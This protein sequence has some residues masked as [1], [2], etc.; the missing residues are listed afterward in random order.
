MSKA[1]YNAFHLNLRLAEI[2]KQARIQVEAEVLRLPPNYCGF[3]FMDGWRRAEVSFI[4]K[5]TPV[6]GL[7]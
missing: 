1:I 4:W 2:D 3:A 6:E 5:R 7:H